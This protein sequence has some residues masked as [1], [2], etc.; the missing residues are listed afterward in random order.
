MTTRRIHHFGGHSIR[1]RLKNLLLGDEIWLRPIRL[2]AEPM[3]RLSERV[4]KEGD[5]EYLEFMIHSSELMPGGSV[6]FK[7]EEAVEK[8]YGVLEDYFAY[9]AAEGYCGKSLQEYAAQQGG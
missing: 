6:F 7:T 4:I 2:T 1:N 8:L 5:G 3:K 9:V